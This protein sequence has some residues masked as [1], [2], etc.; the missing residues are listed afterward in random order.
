MDSHSYRLYSAVRVF[1][2]TKGICYYIGLNGMIANLIFVIIEHLYPSSLPHVQ[3]FLI[4]DLLEAFV[5][6]E[7][8]AFCTKKVMTLDIQSKNRC[9]QFKV[10]YGIVDFVVLK[11]SRGIGYNLSSLHKNAT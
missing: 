10:M 9:Y 11:L 6:C 3:F 1:F 2:P 7:H 8:C 5:I 4:E